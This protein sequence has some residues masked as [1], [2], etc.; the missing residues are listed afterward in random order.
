M[1]CYDIHWGFDS[2]HCIRDGIISVKQYLKL[3][4][5]SDKSLGC[6]D[7]DGD[8]EETSF[9]ANCDGSS[10]NKQNKAQIRRVMLLLPLTT[11][12]ITTTTAGSGTQLQPPNK[13]K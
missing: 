13:I 7:L 3:S 1:L 9:T 10:R 2:V 4:F 5:I 12:T 11:L 8:S 6:F